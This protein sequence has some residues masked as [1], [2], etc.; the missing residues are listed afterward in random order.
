MLAVF[1]LSLLTTVCFGIYTILFEGST[2]D[3]HHTR[4]VFGVFNAEW[5]LLHIFISLLTGVVN[6]KL[7]SYIS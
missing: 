4:G 3:M 2:L 1:L 6:V 5:L 7:F